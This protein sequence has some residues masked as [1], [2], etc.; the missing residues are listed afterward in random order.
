MNCLLQCDDVIVVLVVG[1]GQW[2]ENV[3]IIVRVLSRRL[4]LVQELGSED[5]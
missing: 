2:T 4:H 3:K 1:D 5:L